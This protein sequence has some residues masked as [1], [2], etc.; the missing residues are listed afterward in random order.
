MSDDIDRILTRA[1]LRSKLTEAVSRLDTL[2]NKLER[3]VDVE[4]RRV[5]LGARCTEAEFDAIEKVESDME[6]IRERLIAVQRALGHG[7]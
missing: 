3:Y 4:E 5:D 1:S 2:T 7:D 6:D